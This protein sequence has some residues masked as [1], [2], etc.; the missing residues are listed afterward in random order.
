MLNSL[1]NWADARSI[2]YA[3]WTWNV[4]NSSG[5]SAMKL[6]LSYDGTPNQYGQVVKGHIITL[7]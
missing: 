4:S 7:Q 3:A 6:L 2:G 1:M 5:F